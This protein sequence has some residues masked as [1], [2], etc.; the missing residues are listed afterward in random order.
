MKTPQ[1]TWGISIA[2]LSESDRFSFFEFKD[3]ETGI[4]AMVELRNWNKTFCFCAWPGTN[5]G[6]PT[7]PENLS[8][9][10]PKD[11]PMTFYVVYKHPSD[12]PTSW[13]LRR[14]FLFRESIV[15][16]KRA[17]AVKQSL[18]DLRAVLPQNLANL[19]RELNDDPAIYEVWM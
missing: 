17:F 19:G 2:Q 4:I 13:V 7:R 10:H 15:A 3:P 5:E 12:Y 1:A 6:G 8:R 11:L 18:D 9:P 14:H 16:E